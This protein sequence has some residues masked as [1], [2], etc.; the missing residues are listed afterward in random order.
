MMGHIYPMD[1]L[2]KYKPMSYIIFYTFVYKSDDKKQFFVH[3]RL[4]HLYEIGLKT[5]I[6]RS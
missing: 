2:D 5:S 6:S 3:I 1:I 4:N